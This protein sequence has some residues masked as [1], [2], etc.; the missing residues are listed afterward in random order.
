MNGGAGAWSALAATA[1]ISCGASVEGGRVVSPAAPDPGDVVARYTVTECKDAAGKP[2]PAAPATV[3]VF[4]AGDTFALREERPTSEPLQVENVTEAA[5]RLVFAVTVEPDDGDAVL[6]EYRVSRRGSEPGTLAVV[7]RFTT[8][9][10]GTGFVVTY[11]QATL[12]CALS[13][14][15]LAAAEAVPS[16]SGD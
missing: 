3:R 1:V 14:V 4:R 7:R 12:A 10:T 6:R 5:D 11:P 16:G 15:P 8:T 9:K 13:P 2:S